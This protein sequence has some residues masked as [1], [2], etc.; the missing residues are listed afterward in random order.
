M[1]WRLSQTSWQAKDLSLTNDR[2]IDLPQPT[3]LSSN[4]TCIPAGKH[5]MPRSSGSSA[6]FAGWEVMSL[7]CS[8]R[9]VAASSV[10]LSRRPPCLMR[11][12]VIVSE[13]DAFANDIA[14]Y[15]DTS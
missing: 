13:Q 3:V 12:D 10:L 8:L 14:N 11:P 5:N 15:V 6:A 2:K 1:L 9:C 4:T 7:Q